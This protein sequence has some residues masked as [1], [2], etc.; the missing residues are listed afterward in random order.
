MGP[1]MMQHLIEFVHDLPPGAT[2]KCQ[3]ENEN[4]TMMVQE[5]ITMMMMVQG[6][7]TMMVQEIITMK[8]HSR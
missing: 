1:N 2:H 5:I 4:I 3:N 6:I 8:K 7:I